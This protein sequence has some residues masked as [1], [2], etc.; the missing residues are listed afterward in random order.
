MDALEL[1]MLASL[2]H[3]CYCLIQI[4]QYIIPQP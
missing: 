4:V 3:C 2:D 1:E